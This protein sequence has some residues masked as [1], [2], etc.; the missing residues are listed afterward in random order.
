MAI[1]ETEHESVKN[2][3]DT[4]IFIPNTIYSQR[5]PLLIDKYY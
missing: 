5:P 3:G 4:I 1:I 2:N